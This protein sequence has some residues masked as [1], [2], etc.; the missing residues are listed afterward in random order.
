MR[1]EPDEA[2][3]ELYESFKSALA[4]FGER[5]AKATKEHLEPAMDDGQFAIVLDSKLEAKTQWHPMM[6]A[7]DEPLGMFEFAQVYG[8]ADQ[9]EL[10]TA[11]EQYTA[12]ANEAIAKL[13]EVTLENQQALMER[14]EGQAQMLPFAIAQLRLPSIVLI[15]P[16]CASSRKGWASGHLGL[17]LVEKR[18]W[19]TQIAVSRRSSARSV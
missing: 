3:L 2:D 8:V 15:S 10:E 11:F 17:V 13:K 6:P 18:W 7:S 9:G 14:L 4:P 16:L 5:F 19:K 1:D 12:I